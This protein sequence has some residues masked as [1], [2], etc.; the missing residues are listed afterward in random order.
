MMTASNASNQSKESPME[1]HKKQGPS[2]IMSKTSVLPPKGK[3]RDK[4]QT[5][6]K[7]APKQ[8]SLRE[9]SNKFNKTMDLKPETKLRTSVDKHDSSRM[10]KGSSQLEDF[11]KQQEEKRIQRKKRM[12]DIKKQQEEK[13]AEKFRQ[14]EEVVK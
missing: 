14:D 2:V 1:M 11:Q 4:S 8:D 7:Y 10:S 12:D 3:P 6:N 5:E 9:K 13:R